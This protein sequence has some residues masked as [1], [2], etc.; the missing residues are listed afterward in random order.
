MLL[1]NPR[2]P[3][4]LNGKVYTLAFDFAAIASL[5]EDFGLGL[6]DFKKLGNMKNA[7]LEKPRLLAQFL[8]AMTRSNDGP[9]T[10]KDIERMTPMELSRMVQALDQAAIAGGSFGLKKGSPAIAKA[11]EESE[12][13][14]IGG[15]RSGKRSTGSVSRRRKHGG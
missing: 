1:I 13:P 14:L 11:G 8:Y 6:D 15:S 2:I 12:L 5:K 10:M 3:V 9:P 4:R 7:E